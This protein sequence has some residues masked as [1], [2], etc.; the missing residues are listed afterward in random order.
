MTRPIPPDKLAEWVS[1]INPLNETAPLT[2]VFTNNH[3]RGQAVDTARQ[4]KLMLGI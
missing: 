4:I 1:K 3:W 2:L